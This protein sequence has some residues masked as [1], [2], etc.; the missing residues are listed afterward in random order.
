M[1]SPT[2]TPPSRPRSPTST[3]SP[4]RRRRANRLSGGW[5]RRL[6]LAA[7]LIHQPRLILLDEP[8]AGLDADARLDVWRRLL[9]LARGGASVVI[10]THDLAEAEQARPSPCSAP[11]AS[12]LMATRTP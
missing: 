11:A 7:A 10:N 6:Q 8:T 12:W 2:P 9:A 1:A 5:A 4:Y 3:C